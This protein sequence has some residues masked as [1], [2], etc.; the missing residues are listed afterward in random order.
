MALRMKMAK[1][2]S[3]Q[4]VAP[5]LIRE[6]NVG[7]AEIITIYVQSVVGVIVLEGHVVKIARVKC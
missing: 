5:P 7:L 3:V 1:E 2:N 6:R 4:A